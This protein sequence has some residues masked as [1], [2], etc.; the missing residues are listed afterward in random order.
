MRPLIIAA[1]ALLL[2]AVALLSFAVVRL[3][4]YR[5]A[6]SLGHCERFDVKNPQQRLAREQCLNT[7]VTPRYWFIHLLHG[8]G[9]L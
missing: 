3:E 9:L 4:S 2:S 5:Y 7:A 8:T 6:N 1:I